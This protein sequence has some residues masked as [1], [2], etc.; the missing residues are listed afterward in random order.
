MWLHRQL[1]ERCQREIKGLHHLLKAVNT[2]SSCFSSSNIQRCREG[3]CLGNPQGKTGPLDVRGGVLGL[4]AAGDK[5]LFPTCRCADLPPSP[6]NLGV[7]YTQVLH[8][9]SFAA[10]V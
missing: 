9:H 8:L 3:E 5:N 6:P 7:A 1:A 2:N 10:E 4:Q